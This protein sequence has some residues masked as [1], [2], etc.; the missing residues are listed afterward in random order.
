MKRVIGKLNPNDKHVTIWGAGFAGLILGYYLKAEGYKVTIFEKSNVIGGKIHTKKTHAGL[1]EKGPN[2]LF[3]NADSMDLLHEL[4]LEPLPATK[5]LRRLLMIK[6]KPKR[7]IQLSL[8]TKILANASKK[9]PLIADGLSVAEF[10]KPLI[11]QDKIDHFL[12]PILGGIYATSANELHFKSIFHDVADAAQ[13]SSY[14]DFFRRLSSISKKKPKLTISGSVSFNGGMQTL[15]DR[16]GKEL[17][18]EIKLNSKEPFRIKGNT[19]ICTDA[20]TASELTQN[21]KPDISKELSHIKYQEIASVTTFLKR[22]IKSLQ[23][24]FGVLIPLDSTLK[25]I[26]VI[27]NK[28]I[29]PENNQNVLSYTFISKKKFTESEIQSDIKKLCPDFENEDIDYMDQSH[30]EKGLPIYNLSRYLTVKKLHQICQG[31]EGLAI[32]GNYVAGISLREMIS[33]ARSFAKN[34][35]EYPPII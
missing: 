24:A 35:S 12:T 14:W 31:E 34:P 27:N 26:G 19:I 4:G 11:G 6:D 18:T 30:W 20:Y 28:A 32:F 29:F 8:I 25:S 3:M 9:P 2:A 13:F 10:F 7:A 5:K 17:K 22:E 16:L 33:A 1:V 15:I 23:K 21:L